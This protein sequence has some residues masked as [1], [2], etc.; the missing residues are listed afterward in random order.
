MRKVG[1]FEINVFKHS[2]LATMDML[3]TTKL[4]QKINTEKSHRQRLM[5]H[6]WL[7]VD[8]TLKG[9]K[10]W[11]FQGTNGLKLPTILIIISKF[12]MYLRSKWIFIKLSLYFR[13]NRY[14]TVTTN[15]GAL[16]I[17]GWGG[18]DVTTV[19]CY[20]N[21][22]WSKLDDLQSARCYHRAITNG[23]KVYVIGGSGQQ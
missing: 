23:D 2:D 22:G 3:F 7:L 6:P 15:Q 16:F 4:I 20:N 12:H 18:S 11:I 13:I 14:A 10:S 19:A 8:S 17:G 5:E 1:H 9:L 21:A